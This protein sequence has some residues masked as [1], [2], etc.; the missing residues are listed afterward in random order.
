MESFGV[1]RD[2]DTYRALI[3]IM[4]KGKYVPE[5]TIQQQYSHFPKQQDCV[6]QVLMQMSENEVMPDSGEN[7]CL[8]F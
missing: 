5:N 6:V 8:V 3:D 7:T 4:P 1:H 2:L